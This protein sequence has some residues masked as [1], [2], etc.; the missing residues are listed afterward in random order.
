MEKKTIGAWLIHHTRKLQ[1]VTNRLGFDR[2]EFAG[3][4]GILLSALSESNNDSLLSSKQ[5]ESIAK[6]AGINIILELP[7]ILDKLEKSNYINRSAS[8][9]IYVLGITSTGVLNN[10]NDIFYGLNPESKESISI[11]LAEIASQ[12]PIKGK[13][14]VE[15]L[16]DEYRV[17]NEVINDLVSTSESIGFVDAENIEDDKLLFNGNLFRRD[18]AQKAYMIL[19]SLKPDEVSKINELEEMLISYGCVS[20]EQALKILGEGV[21]KKLQAIGMYD[22]NSISNNSENAY[23]LTKPSA[24]SKFGNPFVEDIFDLAKAFVTA[25]TY[26]MTRSPNTRGKIR[27]LELLMKKMIRGEWVGPA[28]AIGEDYKILELKRVVE[29]KP[30]GKNMFRMRLLKKEIGELAL[31]VLTSGDISE[32]SLL[33]LPG[34]NVTQ[35]FGPEYNR[36][37]VRKKQNP[38]SKREVL[39]VLRTLRKRG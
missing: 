30:E 4:C 3:K 2:I 38:Q 37:I 35:Y 21:F 13:I 34:A 15:R 19:N 27:M 9:D 8:G 12:T 10:T 24:F 16:S 6:A 31:Q 5:I 28:T 23:F 7:T 14:V 32:T 26:G 25:L 29:V 33:G 11:E 36:E 22:V 18:N 20:Y 1:Q 39:D 17:S